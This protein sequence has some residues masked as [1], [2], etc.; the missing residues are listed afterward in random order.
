MYFKSVGNFS[1]DSKYILLQ[2]NTSSNF[3]SRI[4]KVTDRQENTVTLGWDLIPDADSYVLYDLF[5]Y[6]D[7]NDNYI[8]DYW[9]LQKILTTSETSLY[10]DNYGQYLDPDTTYSWKL[11]AVKWNYG[12]DLGE[13]DNL[14][15]MYENDFS[16][17]YTVIHN[18]GELN[19]TTLPSSRT[20]PTG[21]KVENAGSTSVSLRWNPVAGASHY[22]VWWWNDYDNEWQYIEEAYE[23]HYIDA[24]EEF[25]FPS[26]SYKYYVDA[27]FGNNII[28]KG[29]NTVTANTP[30]YKSVAGSITPSFAKVSL[31]T[32]SE[33]R[34]TTNTASY[35][36]N[37]SW[38]PLN[39][40]KYKVGIFSDPYSLTP[41]KTQQFSSSYNV[42]VTVPSTQHVYYVRLMALADSITKSDSGWSYRE[43]AVIFPQIN[44]PATKTTTKTYKTVNVTSSVTW[45]LGA[46]TG[47]DYGWTAVDY[48]TGTILAQGYSGSVKQFPVTVYTAK[49]FYLVIE[50]F[51]VDG[52]GYSRGSAKRIG[53]F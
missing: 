20:G 2:A 1:G 21:L 30:A 41:L 36:I 44:Y 12:V 31:S 8:G 51:I 42:K 6:Y 22:M 39:T 53:P 40:T 52:T 49:Q 48:T 17:Y 7:D 43:R 9:H 27:R 16:K 26:S 28:S 29:S 13:V 23:T 46:G 34:V 47:W 50:P 3:P 33:P 45:K 10:D 24:D 5:E 19:V 15:D 11:L 35:T 25:I 38:T 32:P 37:V 4:F 18:F 14:D